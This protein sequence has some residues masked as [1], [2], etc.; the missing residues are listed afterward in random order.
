MRKLW[1]TSVAAAA[2]LTTAFTAQAADLPVKAPMV[3]PVPVFTWTGVYF[4]FHLGGG[5]F[6]KSW[7]NPFGPA[8]FGDT[9]DGGG[10]LGGGQVGFNY[11]TGAWVLGLEADASAAQ[12]T[13]SNTCLVGANVFIGGVNCEARVG[14]LATLTGRLGYAVDRTLFY[15]KGGGAWASDRFSLNLVPFTAGGIFSANNDRGG[16]T[17]GAGIEHAIIPNVTVKLEYNYLAM[18]SDHVRFNLPPGLALVDNP[19][20]KQDMHV[21]KLGVNYL[22]NWG[23]APVVARY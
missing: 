21:A 9:I 23:P 14:A 4:G 6:H 12:L 22:F 13:G 18:G 3:A 5:H 1:L 2:L 19:A 20:V 7:Q 15:V 10:W 11:Q 17:V 8:V 16:W